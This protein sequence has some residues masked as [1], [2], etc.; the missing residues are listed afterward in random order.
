MMVAARRSESELTEDLDRIFR[1]QKVFEDS[2]IAD[3]FGELPKWFPEPVLPRIRQAIDSLRK[4]DQSKKRIVQLVAS[5]RD[6]KDMQIPGTVH[7]VDDFI[8]SVN[9]LA[10]VQWALSS[11][12]AKALLELAGRDAVL[13]E[14]TRAQRREYSKRSNQGKKKLAAEKREAW[15]AIGKPLRARSPGK[16]NTWLAG[17]IC[18][19]PKADASVSTIRQALPSLGLQ[20]KKT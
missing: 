5:H 20:K 19:N 16:S 11:G 10:H 1:A 2:A 14:R 15:L 13:G 18:R 6:D 17:E 4:A 9:Y 7:D 8:K 3:L 12:K